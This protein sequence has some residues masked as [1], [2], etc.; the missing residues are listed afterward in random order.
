MAALAE[1]NTSWKMVQPHD[2]LHERTWGQ[3]SAIHIANSYTNEFPSPS[4]NQAGGTAMFTLSNMTHQVIEKTQDLMGQWT[5]TKIQGK[6]NHSLCLISAYRCVRNLH[7]PLSVWNQQRQATFWIQREPWKTRLICLTNSWVCSLRNVWR[8]ASKL[9]QELTSTKISESQNLAKK[10]DRSQFNRHL[11]LQ[12]WNSNST[13]L[14]E[15]INP[16]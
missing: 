12:T 10:N 4:A 3:F 13:N 14:R 11:H 5:S 16:N 1:I 6:Q 9:F 15:R 7:G 8:R 2:Q